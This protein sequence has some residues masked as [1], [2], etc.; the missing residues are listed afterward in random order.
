MRVLLCEI[1]LGDAVWELLQP[2]NGHS[3][4]RN[5]PELNQTNL[6]PAV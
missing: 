3:A 5:T 2:V 4:H 6:W 1:K